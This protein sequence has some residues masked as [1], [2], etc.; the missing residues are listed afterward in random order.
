MSKTEEL[1]ISQTENR[2]LKDTITTLREVLEKQKIE[3]EESVQNA[4]VT[5]NDEIVQLKATV[6]ALRDELER[7]KIEYEDKIQEIERAYISEEN[8]LKEMIK[9]LRDKLNEHEKK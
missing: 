7:I 8:Q 9:V 4:L 1:Y 6:G 5:V 2:H 3:N